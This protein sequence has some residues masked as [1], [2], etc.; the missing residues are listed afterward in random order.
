MFWRDVEGHVWTKFLH[1][2]DD[3]FDLRG[4]QYLVNEL[5]LLDELLGRFR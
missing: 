5:A 1:Q 3:D 4:G 2:V